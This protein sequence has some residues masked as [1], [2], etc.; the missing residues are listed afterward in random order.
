M[1]RRIQAAFCSAV[2]SFRCSIWLVWEFGE[3]LSS[4]LIGMWFPLSNKNTLLIE[5]FYS[6]SEAR[7]SYLRHGQHCLGEADWCER[8]PSEELGFPGT[9]VYCMTIYVNTFSSNSIVCVLQ[10]DK[11]PQ[12]EP[13]G[14]IADGLELG[15][16]C[17]A[18]FAC[19]I[20]EGNEARALHISYH[21]TSCNII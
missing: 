16:W 5:D 14:N 18:G 8:R 15:G 1:K 9:S 6:L 20:S 12:S 11:N 13:L 17:I 21:F 3:I 2:H 10:A 19:C 7:G 4:H